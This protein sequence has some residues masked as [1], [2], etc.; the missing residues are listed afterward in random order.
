MERSYPDRPFVGVGIVVL[1]GPD[2]LLIRRGQAPRIGQ[3]SLPGGMQE[4]G[5]TVFEAARRELMEETGVEME[6]PV[7]IDV[8]DAI[9]HDGDGR[10]EYH[11]TLI[12]LAA[13]WRAGRPVAGSD[14]MEATWVALADVPAIEMWDETHRVIAQAAGLLG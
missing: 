9:R 12:D 1:K 10:V 14:A 4:V 13:R 2:V 6:E 7:L 3:W 11:Y 8:I 5:E